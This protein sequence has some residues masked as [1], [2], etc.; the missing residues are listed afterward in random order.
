M[1]RVVID[2]SMR[3]ILGDAEELELCDPSGRKVGHYL[4]EQLYRRLLYDWANAQVTDEELQR[5]RQQPGGRKLAEIWAR[6]E[7]PKKGG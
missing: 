3:A 7:S 5:R 4:S 2:E 1:N 6:V